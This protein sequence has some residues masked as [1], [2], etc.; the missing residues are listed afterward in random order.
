MSSPYSAPCEGRQN[1]AGILDN[2]VTSQ[3]FLLGSYLISPIRD[4]YK[5]IDN[6]YIEEYSI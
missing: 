4:C 2:I 6:N 3:C 5:S 1:L